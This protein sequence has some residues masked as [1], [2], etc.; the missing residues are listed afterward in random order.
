M[1]RLIKFKLWLTALV[2]TLTPSLVSAAPNT[3]TWV[4]DYTTGNCSS[5]DTAG[6]NNA[7]K[8]WETTGGRLE[9]GSGCYTI[10]APGLNFSQSTTGSPVYGTVE[11]DGPNLAQIHCASGVGRCLQFNQYWFGHLQGFSVTG[12][13]YGNQD[14]SGNSDYGL[15]LSNNVQDLGSQAGS[16]QDVRVGGFARCFMLG[17]DSYPSPNGPGAAAEFSLTNV[18]GDYC[19]AG[20]WLGGNNSGDFIFNK[21][22]FTHSGSAFLAGYGAP[23]QLSILGGGATNNDHELSVQGDCAQ[24]SMRDY[25]SE[26]NN[27][28]PIL[29]GG[30]PGQKVTIENSHLNASATQAPISIQLNNGDTQL[31]ADNNE[32]NGVIQHVQGTSSITLIGNTVATDPSI[33]DEVQFSD[34]NCCGAYYLIASQNRKTTSPNGMY[35]GDWWPEYI[36]GQ[37]FLPPNQQPTPTPTPVVATATVAAPT[38]TATSL[39]SPSAT[40]VPTSTPVP[41]VQPTQC[42]VNVTASNA[43]PTTGSVSFDVHFNVPT[44]Q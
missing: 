32:L 5:D 16:I 31:I 42:T 25:R 41:T 14:A 44:C 28:I 2:L 13:G 3:E 10:S 23:F 9:L 20:V 26:G 43:T 18:G 7:I 17:D 36:G 4:Q 6:F 34:P 12:A 19:G 22:N 30:C 1:Q 11:G 38:S 37:W 29:I 8:H 39:P 21:P 35:P 33:P 15:V 24:F 40:P 27:G